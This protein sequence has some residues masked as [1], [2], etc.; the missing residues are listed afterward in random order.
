MYNIITIHKPT[1]LSEQTVKVNSLSMIPEFLREAIT[2]KN[3][4]LYLDTINGV[5]VAPL[6][7]LIGYEEC[8]NLTPSGYN[9]WQIAEPK[10]IQ[11][12]LIPELE[13]V[14][15]LWVNACNLIYNG[16]GT[17]TLNT[18]GKNFTGRIGIDFL[19]CHGMK[20]NGSPDV[21]ILTTDDSSY[22]DYII[23]TDSGRD[24]GALCEF[25]TVS[26]A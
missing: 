26:K 18:N 4:Q 1:I 22:N 14:K 6:G 24:I 7:A 21:S 12:M 10:L 23:R 13:E 2:V 19:L 16:D 17:A 15:P 5:E 3:C 20:A 8:G 25:Y 11:A 9:C